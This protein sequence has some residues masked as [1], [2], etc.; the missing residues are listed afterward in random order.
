MAPYVARSKVFSDLN[1]ADLKPFL[2]VAFGHM[3]RYGKGPRADS[4]AGSGK[5]DATPALHGLALGAME[6]ILLS[7][8]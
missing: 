8:W 5:V 1:V 3:T 7:G 6:S 4:F 2:R